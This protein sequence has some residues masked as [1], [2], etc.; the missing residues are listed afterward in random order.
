L[1]ASLTLPLIVAGFI[2]LAIEGV[3]LSHL[4]REAAASAKK[5]RQA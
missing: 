2:A 4:H 5:R 1:W 3:N